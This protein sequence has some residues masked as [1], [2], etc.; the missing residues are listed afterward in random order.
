MYA[1]LDP[2]LNLRC[3]R[4]EQLQIE[5]DEIRRHRQLSEDSRSHPRTSRW[6]RRTQ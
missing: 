2:G 3:Q 5:A 1:V 6:R 4:W